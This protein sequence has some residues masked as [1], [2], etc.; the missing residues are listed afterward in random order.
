MKKD[1]EKRTNKRVKKY[2]LLPVLHFIVP[3]VL[4]IPAALTGNELTMDEMK[5]IAFNE[6]RDIAA[7]EC[8]VT[9]D[10][11]DISITPT[12]NKYVFI[13][14]VTYCGEIDVLSSYR[15]WNSDN[16][17]VMLY[18]NLRVTLSTRSVRTF[19]AKTGSFI[20]KEGGD[21]RSLPSDEF[22]LIKNKKYYVKI[23]QEN[24][25]LPPD[26]ESGKPRKGTSHV[27]WISD[28]PFL[29]GRPQ[30]GLTPMYK[31]WSY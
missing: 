3:A 27:L 8:E 16:D 13:Q 7:G 4:I 24:Y 6:F 11:D 29:K 30:V 28:K 23:T 10:G 15:T 1:G 18:K 17:F 14:I 9:F 26:R 22:G 25:H 5:E 12:G 19:I 2:I 20:Q 21:E 31:N